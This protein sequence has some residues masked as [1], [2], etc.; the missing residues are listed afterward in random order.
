M[1][2]HFPRESRRVQGRYRLLDQRLHPIDFIRPHAQIR[3]RFRRKALGFHG[4]QF[5]NGLPLRLIGIEDVKV[6]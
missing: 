3:Q 6:Q 5:R 4:R 1:R 2:G